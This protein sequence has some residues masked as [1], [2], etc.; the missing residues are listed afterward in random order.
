DSTDSARLRHVCRNDG[1][2][3][4]QPEPN[5]PVFW[6]TLR[7]AASRRD[8]ASQQQSLREW[9]SFGQLRAPLRLRLATRK[10]AEP[11][12]CAP[13]LWMVLPASSREGK[14]A[15]HSF[16]EYAAPCPTHRSF[17]SQ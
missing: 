10:Q 16:D 8:C 6:P 15:R 1:A 7:V 12:G 2:F 17:G 11:L 5:Q 13:W 9:C 14:C 4:L 3:G